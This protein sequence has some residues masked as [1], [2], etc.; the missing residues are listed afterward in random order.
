MVMRTDVKR[1]NAAD[2]GLSA[3]MYR[4]TLLTFFKAILATG[5]N[6]KVANITSVNGNVVTL[7]Y[8]V[9][10]GYALH[11]VLKISGNPSLNGEH[12]ATS[13]TT[14]TLTI[15]LE[16]TVTITGTVT[17]QVAPLGFEQVYESANVAI[18]K[19]NY[20]GKEK[21]LRLYETPAYNAYINPSVGDGF[22]FNNGT[23]T[24]GIYPTT[25]ISSQNPYRW[26]FNSIPN[27]V[28]FELP[29]IFGTSEGFLLVGQMLGNARQT[30]IYGILPW[31]TVFDKLK[32]PI[33]ICFEITSYS[34]SNG[35]NLDTRNF[36]LPFIG[37][38]HSQF[39]EF[40]TN[41]IGFSSGALTSPVGS[42]IPDTI[43]GFNA[44]SYGS[45]VI[46]QYQ[47]NQILGIANGLHSCLTNATSAN[48][49][50]SGVFESYDAISN[51]KIW[52]RKL[53]ADY[54]YVVLTPFEGFD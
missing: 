49:T 28:P 15:E 8:G 7:D 3:N 26:D 35:A 46:Q 20:K 17:T 9:P 18:Y 53:D 34:T 10:H 36:Y 40:S 6:S 54:R 47:T 23:L 31:H 4:G 19:F 13:I 11:R 50:P 16:D 27:G 41:N 5:Y 44:V 37:R 12:V 1:F 25:N 24:G 33:L 42:S 32:T 52:L 48:N 43:V 45:L 14:N 38:V 30:Y 29:S 39:N 21:Y 22:N 51:E 2:V